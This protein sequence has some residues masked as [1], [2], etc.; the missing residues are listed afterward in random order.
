[1]SFFNTIKKATLTNA[2]GE[3]NLFRIDDG[4]PNL[5][6]FVK[7]TP[8][9]GHFIVGHSESGHNHLLEGSGVSMMEKVSDGM[10]I[11]Y[12]IVEKPV[13][14]KQSAGDPH[15][16]QIVQPGAYFSTNNVDYDPF[17]KQAR[18]VAD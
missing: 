11:L 14:L 18:R 8:S 3:V 13:A 16:E 9:E 10:R 12:A 17:L 7:V 15:K 6:G 5:S 4:N 2:H 1:M